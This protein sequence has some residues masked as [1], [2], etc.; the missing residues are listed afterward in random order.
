MDPFSQIFPN[1]TNNYPNL[2][3]QLVISLLILYLGISVV[4]YLTKKRTDESVSFGLD[5]KNL[6]GLFFR[7]FIWRGFGFVLSNIIYLALL[8]S[9]QQKQSDPDW[10]NLS[11]GIIL[12]FIGLGMKSAKKRLI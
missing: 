7:I 4:N 8:G 5:M 2:F 3:I 9:M 6:L 1:P 11:F 10:T 12:I